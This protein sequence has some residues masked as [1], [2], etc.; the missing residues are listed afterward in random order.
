MQ[1]AF[2]RWRAIAIRVF[3]EDARVIAMP[4]WEVPESSEWR[5]LVSWKLHSDP[6]RPARRSKI[7]QLVVSS[8]AVDSYARSPA[9]ARP[10]ADARLEAWLRVKLGS[11]DG[12][13]DTYEG[14]EP[15]VVSWTLHVRELNGSGADAV[16]LQSCGSE[17]H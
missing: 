9:G 12:D 8:E 15:P 10:S 3:P 6:M 11:F 2:R 14:F 7:V 1:Q 5:L 17:V 4:A 16:G 13:H